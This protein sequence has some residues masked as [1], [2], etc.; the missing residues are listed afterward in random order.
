[1]PRSLSTNFRRD[2]EASRASDIALLFVTFS[3][4]TW[5][6]PVYLVNDVVDYTYNGNHFIGYPFKIQLLADD[7]KPPKGQF[8]IQNVDRRIGELLLGLVFSPRMQIEILAGSGWNTA[9]DGGTNSRLPIGTPTPEY[10]AQRMQVWDVTVNAMTVTMSFG[11]PDVTSELWPV[12]R[13]TK[14]NTP[15]LFR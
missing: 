1:M 13:A 4:E 10:I 5:A 12:P 15:G 6:S 3:H 2:L 7:E 11:P 14:Q 8:I 9:I